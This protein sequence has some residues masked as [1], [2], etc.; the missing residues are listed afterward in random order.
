MHE[1]IE[2]LYSKL[3]FAAIG[4]FITI[5]TIDGRNQQRKRRVRSKAKRR[6]KELKWHI[7][8]QLLPEVPKELQVKIASST[9]SELREG[10]DKGDFTSEQILLAYLK[11]LAKDALIR[12]LISDVKVEEALKEARTLDEELKQGHKRGI[13]HGIPI[14]SKDNFSVKGMIN[15]CG[16]VKHYKNIQNEDALHVEALR[17]QGAIIYALAAVPQGLKS[18]EL[19]NNFT[20][21]G[22]HPQYIDRTPGGS[23]GGV[24]ALVSLGCSAL[25]IGDDLVGSIRVPASFCGLAGFRATPKR[26]SAVSPFGYTVGFPCLNVSFGAI[27]KVVDDC[28]VYMEAICDKYMHQRDLSIPPLP[29]N[30]EKYRD[31]RKLKI[32]YID[33]DEYW[34]LPACM[35]RAVEVAK[36]TLRK[37][38]HEI[39]KIQPPSL[40]DVNFSIIAQTMNSR[41]YSYWNEP[42]CE[43]FVDN[44]DNPLKASCSFGIKDKYSIYSDATSVTNS[45]EFVKHLKKTTQLRNDFLKKWADLEIDAIIAPYPV[46]AMIHGSNQKLELGFAYVTLFSILEC[47]VGNVPIGIIS[48]D[49]QSYPETEESW[50]KVMNTNMQKSKGLPICVQ[51]AA[52]PY[53]D[54]LCLNVMSQLEANIREKLD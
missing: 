27:G 14:V 26:I 35:A 29:W 36:E 20:K 24:A 34:P 31:Q 42:E 39:V 12:N 25:G 10:L 15:T 40:E 9:L 49:E 6:I 22:L 52:S 28:V 3:A 38:G 47:P 11:I 37:L 51:I 33:S 48:E 44:L 41:R 50:T 5:L 23:S 21:R 1:W 7:Q 54:E 17:S 16:W 32:G 53:Q 13:L 30:E 4:A 46:P 2:I 19:F 18:Y 43:L 8:G 45:Y